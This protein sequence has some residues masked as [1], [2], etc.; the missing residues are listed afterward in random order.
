MNRL[1][2]FWVQRPDDDD[3]DDTERS[4]HFRV[5]EDWLAVDNDQ[6]I[7][8]I[9]LIARNGDDLDDS[10][11]GLLKQYGGEGLLNDLLMADD[12]LEAGSEWVISYDQ[13]YGFVAYSVPTDD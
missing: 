2:V 10:Q 5:T 6:L 8:P 11:P 12:D 3:P 9:T 13:G 1:P 7:L 4:I